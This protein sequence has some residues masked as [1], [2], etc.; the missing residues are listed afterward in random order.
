MSLGEKVELLWLNCLCLFLWF[1]L[2]STPLIMI[3]PDL[4][5]NILPSLA[6]NEIAWVLEMFRRLFFNA[7][8]GQDSYTVAIDYIKSDF[9][10]EFLAAFPQVFSYLDQQYA[11]MKLFRLYKLSL[12]VIPIPTATNL[13][14]QERD[15][16]F[17]Q[18]LSGGLKIFCYI[19]IL[20]HYL[21]CLW[22]FIGSDYFV[23]FEAGAVPWTLNSDDFANLDEVQLTIYATYWVC[24]VV[25]SVGYGDYTGGTTLEYLFTISIEF[26]GFMIYAVVQY[27]VLQF[28]QIDNHYSNYLAEMDLQAL[29]WFDKLEKSKMQH[30]IP[31]ELFE[32]LKERIYESHR[33]DFCIIQQNDFYNQLSPKLQNELTFQLFGGFLHDFATFFAGCN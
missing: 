18:A 11:F 28:I 3:F 30:S 23:E 33:S 5:Q 8:E 16:K 14:F 2:Y 17:T 13:L 12:T 21:G 26:A 10:F 6:L 9:V 31:A 29:I 24:T 25:T 27:A 22:V 15:K 19:M 4:N 7:E 32:S 20:I 1:N